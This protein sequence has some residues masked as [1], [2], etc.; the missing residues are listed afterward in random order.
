MKVKGQDAFF[1]ARISGW[2]QSRMVLAGRIAS[3]AASVS[4]R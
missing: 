1:F 2:D 4:A 3:P